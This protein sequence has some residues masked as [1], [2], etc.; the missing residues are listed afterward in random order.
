M[1]SP[2]LD[3]NDGE[4]LV[5]LGPSGCVKTTALRC[6]AGLETPDG[7]EIFVGDWLVNDYLCIKSPVTRY[8]SDIEI[9]QFADSLRT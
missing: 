8:S 7:G 2:S 4:F 9:T 5:L 6:V 3:V 1:D